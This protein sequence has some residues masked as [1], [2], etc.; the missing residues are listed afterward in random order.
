MLDQLYQYGE[1]GEIHI[2]DLGE[3]TFDEDEDAT[4]EP[5]IMG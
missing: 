4:L 3:I 5:F 2:N 1:V